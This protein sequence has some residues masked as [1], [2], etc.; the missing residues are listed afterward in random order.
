LHRFRVDANGIM[1]TS[2]RL[3]VRFGADLGQRLF[4]W[5]AIEGGIRLMPWMAPGPTEKQD[6]GLTAT[7]WGY[8]LIGALEGPIVGFLGWR[9]AYDY[10]HFSD[11]YSGAGA[12]STGGTGRSGYHTVT[13]SATAAW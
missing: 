1:P 10:L 7:G 6:F 2:R 4:P 9:A 3:G 12:L 11:S 13:A 8:Q 5:L